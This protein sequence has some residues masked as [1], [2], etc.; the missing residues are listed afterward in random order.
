MEDEE[1]TIRNIASQRDDKYESSGENGRIPICRFS[2]M[3]S[4]NFMYLFI[5]RF[6]K[7]LSISAS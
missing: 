1:M 3:S 6:R 2:N 5:M 7:I 4:M